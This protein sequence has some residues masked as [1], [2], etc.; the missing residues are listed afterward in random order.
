MKTTSLA[1][2]GVTL[3]LLGAGCIPEAGPGPNTTVPGAGSTAASCP[4]T[5]VHYF[6][7]LGFSAKEIASLQENVVAPLVAYYAETG[8][9]RVVS[10]TIR[11]TTIGVV[12]EAIVDQNDA[13]DP[14][15]HGFTHERT[16]ADSYPRWYPDEV[17]PEYRG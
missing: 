7:K 13:D 14:V 2:L 9:A 3:A 1:G 6:N 5:Q 16:G 8:E 15:F 10:I 4:A 11:R 12:V 17:P